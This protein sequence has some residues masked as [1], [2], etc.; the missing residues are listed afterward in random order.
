MNQQYQDYLNS[1]TWK[2]I[3]ERKLTNGG[4]IC[5]RCKKR[6]WKKQ[7]NVHH[8]TYKLILGKETDQ[9]LVI[10]CKS[11]HDFIHR[12]LKDGC[13][14]CPS[15][16]YVLQVQLRLDYKDIQKFKDNFIYYCPRCTS[17]VYIKEKFEDVVLGLKLE[18][19]Q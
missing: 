19:F 12:L 13:Y 18:Y 17:E 14:R 3:R 11:C 1:A 5:E 4:C 9:Q 2:K 6:G 16:L 10:L 8:K 15:C 7:L